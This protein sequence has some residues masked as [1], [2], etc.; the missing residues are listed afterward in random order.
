MRSNPR[1]R[2]TVELSDDLTM[3][4]ATE[5]AR[6][7]VQLTKPMARLLGR[8]LQAFADVPARRRPTVADIPE[9]L[10]EPSPRNG[11]RSSST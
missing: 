4:V 5:G 9:H 3:T 1:R 6:L 2:V 8:N 11:K 7:A 10:L